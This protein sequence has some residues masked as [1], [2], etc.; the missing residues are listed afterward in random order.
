MFARNV[1]IRLKPNTLPQFTEIME[2]EI[3]PL[4]Q[5]QSGFRDE[6]T[7]ANAS[8]TFVNAISIWDSQEQANA[9]DKSAYAA[10]LKAVEKLTEGPP[11]VHPS[12]IVNS[13]L[14]KLSAHA[15]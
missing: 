4:L 11:K 15:A 9:Y 5:K 8:G 14:H 6:I 13:T 3:M 10:V 7:L 12:I 2:K 1:A